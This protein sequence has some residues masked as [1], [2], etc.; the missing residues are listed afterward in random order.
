MGQSAIKSSSPKPPPLPDYMNHPGAPIRQNNETPRMQESIQKINDL[1][2]HP[3]LQLEPFLG[4]EVETDSFKVPS[5]INDVAAVAEREGKDAP[6]TLGGVLDQFKN[7]VKISFQRESNS[8]RE[9]RAGSVSQ[10]LVEEVFYEQETDNK[11]KNFTPAPMIK[12]TKPPSLRFDPIEPSHSHSI[13]LSQQGLNDYQFKREIT[14]ESS[15]LL[16]SPTPKLQNPFEHID[17]NDFLTSSQ[18]NNANHPINVAMPLDI[19]QNNKAREDNGVF[20][21]QQSDRLETILSLGSNYAT[22]DTDYSHSAALLKPFPSYQVIGTDSGTQD[23]LPL[24]N[25]P[26]GHG[27]ENTNEWSPV[28]H[29]PEVSLG[30]QYS[31]DVQSDDM[32]TEGGFRARVRFEE[33]ELLGSSEYD[34]NSKTSRQ[35]RFPQ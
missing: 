9:Q 25:T 29:Y 16:G 1:K 7:K 12:R 17:A 27:S 35:I 30:H 19:S 11:L 20:R 4:V 8:H 26:T 21:E 34:R 32:G 6:N 10:P 5:M 24:Q 28:S 33:E 23:P 3:T 15:I 2:M 18:K 31:R 13:F 22:G 14:T